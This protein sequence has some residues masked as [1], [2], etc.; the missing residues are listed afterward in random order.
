MAKNSDKDGNKETISQ[1]KVIKK[2]KRN[3]G[4]K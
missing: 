2:D 3:E 4:K 1:S